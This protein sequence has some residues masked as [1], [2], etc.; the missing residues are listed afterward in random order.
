MLGLGKAGSPLLVLS[1]GVMGVGTERGV[2]ASLSWFLCVYI[3]ALKDTAW[4]EHVSASCH[5]ASESS[6][7]GFF[8]LGLAY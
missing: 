1:T 3:N 6:W 5:R 7:V 4:S 8:L 2:S